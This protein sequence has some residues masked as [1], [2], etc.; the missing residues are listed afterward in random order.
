LGGLLSM[1]FSGGAGAVLMWLLQNDSG[2]SFF[3]EKVLKTAHPSN[4]YG[5]APPKELELEPGRSPTIQP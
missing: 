4:L 5:R 1:G 3:I 2:S